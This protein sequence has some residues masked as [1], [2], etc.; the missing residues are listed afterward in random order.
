MSLFNKIKSL[1]SETVT[2]ILRYI[3]EHVSVYMDDYAGD[4]RESTRY[5]ENVKRVRDFLATYNFNSDEVTTNNIFDFL[6]NL[7]EET[8]EDVIKPTTPNQR[9]SVVPFNISSDS[10]DDENVNTE[11]NILSGDKRQTQMDQPQQRQHPLFLTTDR[12]NEFRQGL[13]ET[14]VDHRDL[15]DSIDAINYF[16]QHPIPRRVKPKKQPYG[17][18]MDRIAPAVLSGKQD[19]RRIN[20]AQS[21]V[22]AQ[23]WV[24]K[25]GFS[26]I[27]HVTGDDEDGDGIADVIVRERETNRPIIVNG[28]TT[29][30]STYPY[31]YKYYSAYPTED[32]RKEYGKG[33]K[34]FVNDMYNPEYD[35][36]G[37]R[38]LRNRN[39]QGAQFA[40]A[41]E[42]AGY[43]KVLQPHNKTVF[44]VFTSKIINPIY[45]G[46][47]SVN[48]GT[49][50]GNKK[51]AKVASNV[52]E[53]AFVATAMVR[54][55]G[56]EVLSVDEGM[57]KKL[58]S[59]REVRAATDAF[60]SPYL[61]GNVWEKIIS[62]IP[63]YIE[64]EGFNMSPTEVV[65]ITNAF[66]RAA[67]IQEEQLPGNQPEAP[68]Q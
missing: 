63:V 44:Q 2:R 58:K 61:T 22:G 42:H 17:A 15:N 3:R 31:R 29:V 1:G 27:Y 20:N 46:F 38:L 62:F 40:A 19:I 9:S 68:P 10:D 57:W 26:D 39:E 43:T 47:K 51:L 25:H 4:V 48:N 13:E 7:V 59:K 8:F 64:A 6:Y 18:E 41:V 53:K 60:A 16:R 35:E 37:V 28:Y 50:P 32:E 5:L 45:K 21:L 14:G 36:R 33:F 30:D 49:Y 52:W 55:Y 65:Q 56:E 66:R 23:R 54:V 34:G 12:M 24:D 67:G 11:N